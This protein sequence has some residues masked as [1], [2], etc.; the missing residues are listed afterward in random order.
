MGGVAPPVLINN[1]P[2]LQLFGRLRLL[3][4]IKATLRM[5]TACC[6]NVDKLSLST[7]V[8]FGKSEAFVVIGTVD[9]SVCTAIKL[10]V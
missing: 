7:K 4:I 1:L 8:L 9:I 5:H 2:S 10:E 3:G 6:C